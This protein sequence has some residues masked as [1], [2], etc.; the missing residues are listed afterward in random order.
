MDVPSA[1]GIIEDHF[2]STNECPPESFWWKHHADV[3]GGYEAGP[4]TRS[5]LS[6]T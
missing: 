4:Y 2:N 6:S 5:L 3:Y 1:H